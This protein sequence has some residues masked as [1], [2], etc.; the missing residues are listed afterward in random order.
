MPQEHLRHSWHWPSCFLSETEFWT[1][2]ESLYY[3]EPP[4]GLRCSPVRFLITTFALTIPL[5]LSST[6]CACLFRFR[7]RFRLS[8]FTLSWT[9]IGILNVNRKQIRF[10]D[11]K[12]VRK[13]NDDF[14]TVISGAHTCH[15]RPACQRP[16]IQ[17][18]QILRQSPYPDSDLILFKIIFIVL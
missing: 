17:T 11:L 5:P 1:Y 15:V 6:L 12:T 16:H 10:K 7:F 18:L 13:I 2:K 3:K 9:C 4:A 14:H 8:L